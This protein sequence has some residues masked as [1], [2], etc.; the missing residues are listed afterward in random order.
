MHIGHFERLLW[1]SSLPLNRRLCLGSEG[2]H[3]D[4]LSPAH[5]WTRTRCQNSQR[6]HQRGQRAP[7]C[8]TPQS[9]LQYE[10]ETRLAFDRKTPARNQK[11]S[12]RTLSSTWQGQTNSLQAE[13]SPCCGIPQSTLQ[14]GR[15]NSAAPSTGRH[16]L[17]TRRRIPENSLQAEYVKF[18][19]REAVKETS[20]YAS[21]A[22]LKSTNF[23]GMAMTSSSPHG[24]CFSHRKS[25]PQ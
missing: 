20:T 2:G 9:T 19:P 3:P 17:R 12:T 18:G 14:R 11:G 1:C 25:R 23:S 6:L 4:R 13:S 10:E 21:P 22:P 15:G 24:L 5:T 8:G 16:Q 7:C